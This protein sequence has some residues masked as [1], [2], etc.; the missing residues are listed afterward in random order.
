MIDKLYQKC[1]EK[2]DWIIYNL[3][4]H[5]LNRMCVRHDGAYVLLLRMSI[6][7]WLEEYPLSENLRDAAE[8][9]YDSMGEFRNN[10]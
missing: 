5:S 6:D 10:K 4:Y 2:F 1:I 9:F 8:R 3:S 7:A